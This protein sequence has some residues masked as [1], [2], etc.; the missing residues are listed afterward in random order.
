MDGQISRSRPRGHGHGRCVVTPDVSIVVPTRN[1]MTTLPSLV[2]ALDEQDDDAPRELVVVDSN[3]TD[4]TREYAERVATR[5][6]TIAPGDFDHGTTRNV[7]IAASRGRHVVLTVQD[8]RPTHR[9]WLRNLLAPLRTNA[10]V[11]GAFARQVS[12][13]DASA[14]MRAQLSGWVA[15]RTTP[16][17]VQVTAGELETL[18]PH[19]RLDCCAFDHVC[20]AVRR[21]VWS[22][23][24]Y[25]STPIAEDLIWARDAL[26]AGH[27]IAFVPDAV[28]EHSHERTAGYEF[29]R[30]CALHQQLVRLF[31]LR[32]IP[33]LGALGR[34]IAVTMRLH[35]QLAR[36][37][38]AAIGSHGWR[39]AM[40]LAVAWPAGQFVG[41]WTESTGRTRWRPRGI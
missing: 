26:L 11:A 41:G 34:S 19:A 7:G 14:V 13:A 33:S 32:A 40:S 27:A 12:R 5:V 1:G 9:E 29:V 25:Q 24:P 20:A 38:G 21:D 16:R 37:S 3:S 2:R 15:A 36:S 8:A 31:G 17:I 18:A 23:I 4:G 28:V 22:A 30:T 39:R 6:V 10:A 35:H